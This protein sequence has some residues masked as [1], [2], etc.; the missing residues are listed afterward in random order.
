MRP[1]SEVTLRDGTR[2]LIRPIRPGD[3]D[4]LQEGVNRLSPTSRYLRFLHYFER[5]TPSELRYLTEIDY[6]DHFAC[7]AI[8]LDPG[9]PNDG[10]A[11]GV[12]RYIRDSRQ[13]SQAEAAVTVVDDFQRRG[14]GSLLL[15]RLAE[16][17]HDNGIEAFV[18]YLAPENPVVAHLLRS[19]STT[20][21]DEDGLLRVVVPIGDDDPGPGNLAIL[22]A[23]AGGEVEIIPRS[24]SDLRP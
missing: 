17:A 11:L 10:A 12:A 9:T 18:A 24:L 15:S 21:S 6:H 14:L 2:V 1:V 5:L 13:P 16:A 4:L 7:I 3:K 19:V 22:R 20:A 8:S 23:A